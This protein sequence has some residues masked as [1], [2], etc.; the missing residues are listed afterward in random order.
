MNW[1][2]IFQGMIAF[3]AILGPILAYLGIRQGKTT[4]NL[5]NSRMD[6]F[7]AAPSDISKFKE[8]LALAHGKE[9]GKAAEKHG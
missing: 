5:V 9:Q 6:E 3:A 4:H 1:P 2:I 7:K 8:E